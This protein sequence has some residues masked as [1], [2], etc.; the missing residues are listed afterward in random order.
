MRKTRTKRSNAERP[1][2]AAA[3]RLF[4]Q[5]GFAA[6]G[7][8]EIASEAHVSIATLYHYVETKEELLVDIMREGLEALLISS[9]QA[10][11][12]SSA[13]EQELA[14]LA[15]SHVVAHALNQAGARVIDNELRALSDENHEIVVALRD[16]YEELW[17]D[18]LTR[19]RDAEI[20]RFDDLRVTRFALIDMCTG[21][22]RWYSPTGSKSLDELCR[23]LVDLA[24]ALVDARLDG[25][26]IRAADLDIPAPPDYR[27]M[28]PSVESVTAP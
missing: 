2:R 26:R 4:A 13:P 9:R 16:A 21:V 15:Q 6:T 12:G 5:K 14:L 18:V 28:L 23:H 17:T 24:L 1:I 10:V 8:R 20:F 19:G 27:P 22:V 25:R 3:L 11:A 7:I